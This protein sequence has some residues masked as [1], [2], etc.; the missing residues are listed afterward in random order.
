MLP[1]VVDLDGTLI[2]SDSLYENFFKV[3]HNDPWVALCSLW[4]LRQGVSYWKR[5]LSSHAIPSPELL[6]YRQDLLQFLEEEKQKGRPIYLVTAADQHIADAVAAHLGIFTGV[7]G[8]TPSNNLKG[9]EKANYLTA[10]FPDGFDYIGDSIADIPVWQKA[11]TAHLAGRA[12][13]KN[14]IGMPIDKVFADNSVTTKDW[15]K[16]LRVHQWSK[17][18]L[19]LLPWFLEGHFRL[20]VLP[21]VVAV[22]IIF[23]V[24]VSTTYVFNDML[25]IESDRK[26]PTKRLR[27]LASINV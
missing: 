14:K 6:P 13:I 5:F 16:L 8:S 22:F 7:K 23:N 17:N 27:P 20:A 19:V 1:L 9:R 25:D 18:L 11:Q 21:E 26:H 4:K 10:T 12:S 3:F 24:I 15:L 2:T